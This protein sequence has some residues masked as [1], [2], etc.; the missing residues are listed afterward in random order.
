MEPAVMNSSRFALPPIGLRIVERVLFVVGLVL[1]GWYAAQRLTAYYDQRASSRELEEIRMSVAPPGGAD[2]ARNP[3]PARGVLL[4][5][6]QLERV[7]L[8]AIIREGDD[9]GVLRRAVGHIP[10]TALPGEHGNAGLA[11]HRD[12]F[13]RGL[14]DVRF[15]DRI[16]VTTMNS[17]AQYEVRRTRIVDPTDVSVLRPTSGSTLTL[18][19]CYPF[20][21]IGAA[22]KRFIVQA[23]RTAIDD[24]SGR[25]T[26]RIQ[27]HDD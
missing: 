27:T 19:T 4:G 7:G 23:Q 17:V 24:N 20:N 6:I 26:P 21:Y 5:R 8:T 11:G 12:T 25:D 13:F 2:A 14:R 9:T 10:E 3:K 1:V 22:P 15:G 18:V 16:V